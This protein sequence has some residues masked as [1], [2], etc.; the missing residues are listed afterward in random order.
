MKPTGPLRH[1]PLQR[2]TPLRRRTPMRRGR[3]RTSYSRRPR[4]FEFMGWVKR[5][6]C[7][8]RVDPPVPSPTPCFGEVEADH[9]GDRALGRKA[10]DR[11]CAPLCQQHHAERSSRAGSFKHLNREGMRAWR[12]RQIARTQAEWSR[13][14]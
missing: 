8:V 11:T 6:T 7:S 13:V 2:R 14:S 9:M 10:D 4:D 3:K 1:R 5:L 12:T